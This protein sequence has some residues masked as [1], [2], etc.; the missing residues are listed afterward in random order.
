[1]RSA[2]FISVENNRIYFTRTWMGQDQGFYLQDGQVYRQRAEALPDIS[3]VGRFWKIN[4]DQ[5]YQFGIPA[6][7]RR[8]KNQF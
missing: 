4:L 8:F 3:I 5:F 2:G 7:H 1:M 6:I